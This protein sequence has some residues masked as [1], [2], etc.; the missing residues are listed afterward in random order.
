MIFGI[1]ETV[2]FIFV[3]RNVAFH[4][5]KYQNDLLMTLSIAALILVFMLKNLICQI[6]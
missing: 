1:I 4:Y 2:L 5:F 3:F 6:F